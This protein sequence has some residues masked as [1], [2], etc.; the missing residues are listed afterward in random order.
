MF[1][2]NRPP[3][4][5]LQLLQSIGGIKLRYSLT[6]EHDNWILIGY[7]GKQKVDWIAEKVGE[8]GEDVIRVATAVHL[9]QS[10]SFLLLDYVKLYLVLGIGQTLSSSGLYQ[11][12]GLHEFDQVNKN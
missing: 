1:L 5:T 8:K 9:N 6:S 4:H 3:E 11:V 2:Y 10:R 7:K 12:P